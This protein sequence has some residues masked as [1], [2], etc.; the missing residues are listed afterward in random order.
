MTAFQTYI[1]LI[2]GY[3]GACVLFTPK[4]YANGGYLFSTFAIFFSG[5]F[6]TICAVKLIKIG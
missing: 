5:W 6:T 1:A 4:A 3:V 2:K